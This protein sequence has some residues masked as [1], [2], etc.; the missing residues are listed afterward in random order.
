MEVSAITHRQDAV[1]Q[2]IVPGLFDE[3]L[4]I[5]AEAIATTLF[6]NLQ[7]AVP[8]VA[9]VHIPLSGGGRLQAVVALNDPAPGEA[10]KAMFAVW[11]HC[12]LVKHVIVVDADVNIRSLEAVNY[13]VL[14]R[15]RGE[16]DL[17]IVPGV[18][19][20]RAEP[21]EANRTVTKIGM[22]ALRQPHGSR[23]DFVRTEVPTAVREKI[24]ANWAAYSG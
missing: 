4:L 8:S 21:L 2:T 19:A 1:F 16:Q 13:A 7:R 9:E 12:N 20:D 23:T 14:T 24:K 6:F 5:G 22:V 18:R 10:Q 17:V 15:M 3:H 11:A